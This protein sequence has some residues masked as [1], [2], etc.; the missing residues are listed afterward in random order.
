MRVVFIVQGEGRGHL[1]QA[2]A[3]APLLR[4]AGH[5]VVAACVG[6]SPTRSLPAFFRDDIGAPV[7]AFDEP[8]FGHRGRGIRPGATALET[9]RRVP[10]FGRA[11]RV[12]G[13]VA[14]RYRPDVIV[15]FYTAMGGLYAALGRP[16]VP[17]VAVGHQYFFHHPAYPFPAGHR[18]QRLA[19]KGYTRLTALG[20][21]QRLALSFYPAPDRP[22]LRV[23]PP[24]LREAVLAQQRGL[25]EGFLLV[26]LLNAGYA[27]EVR[28][29]STAHPHVPI[30]CFRDAPGAAEVRETDALT[31]HRLDGA[32]FVHL[33]ARCRG[34]VCTAG[35]ESVCEAMYL[36]KPVLMVPVEGHF[37]QRCNARDAEQ[38]GAGL[39]ARTFD[40]GRLLDA[41]DAYRPVPGFRDWVARAPEVYVSEIEQAA[42]WRSGRLVLQA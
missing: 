14:D 35:F 41:A 23:V 30:H 31:F 36:E 18:V 42:E 6:T 26:Y 40:F 17:V 1:T 33:M 16:G 29:W 28:A 25:D 5:E 2:L 7:V 10:A 15:N 34:L 38:T 32:K 8:G 27:S 4:R 19:A 12:L 20:A 11:L 9:L 22:G 13:G 24:L 39:Y 21:P 37:E 3:L